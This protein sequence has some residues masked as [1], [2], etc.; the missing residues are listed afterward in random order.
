MKNVISQLLV[1]LFIGSAVISCSKDQVGVDPIE[2]QEKTLNTNTKQIEVSL[3]AATNEPRVYQNVATSPKTTPVLSEADIDVRVVIGYNG[4]YEHQTVTFKKVKGENKATFV[5]KLNVPEIGTDN[6]T[7]TA[8]ILGQKDGREYASLTSDNKLKVKPTTALLVATDNVVNS[9]IPYLAQATAKLSADGKAL[10]KTTLTFKPSGT[11]L[12]IKLTNWTGTEKT[13]SKVRFVSNAFVADWSYD[14]TNINGGNLKA[15]E[16]VTAS[17]DQVFDLPQPVT[18]ADNATAA[19]TYYLWVMGTNV[20]DNL[21]TK[22]FAVTS[23]GVEIRALKRKTPIKEGLLTA[24]IKPIPPMPLEYLGQ[25]ALVGTTAP[26]SFSSGATPTFYAAEEIHNLARLGDITI[27]GKQYYMPSANEIRSIFHEN[28]TA[29]KPTNTNTT[30]GLSVS[31]SNVGF[32]WNPSAVIKGTSVYKGDGANLVYGLR[33]ETGN[34]RY[35]MAYRYEWIGTFAVTSTDSKLRITSRY[36]GEDY[37]SATIETIANEVFWSE[38]KE[39]DVTVDLRTH[40]YIA[41]DPISYGGDLLA[42]GPINE[43]GQNGYI[44]AR[45]TIVGATTKMKDKQGNW[46]DAYF[47]EFIR[48]DRSVGMWAVQNARIDQRPTRLFIR[49]NS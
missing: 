20:T 18:L 14:L 16:A 35:L 7:I 25:D 28:K 23:G 13:F 40:G 45:P 29:I 15:G 3:T 22:V 24:H 4:Q 32:P 19:D 2:P 37:K 49:K 48:F 46:I 26:F 11:L 17:T 42:T 27:D 31:F 47:A 41:Y 12:Q 44:Y 39:E 5:G 36:L 38:D 10:E 43:A 21:L 9:T 33:F 1:L 6:Y 34:S 8:A 30:S